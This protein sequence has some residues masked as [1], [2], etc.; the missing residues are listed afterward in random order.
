MQLPRK[1]DGRCPLGPSVQGT[2]VLMPSNYGCP[3]PSTGTRL[4]AG[5]Q[6]PAG[7]LAERIGKSLPWCLAWL[8]ALTGLDRWLLV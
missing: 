4:G 1:V 8:P 5:Q 7:R 6:E 3:R 2:P